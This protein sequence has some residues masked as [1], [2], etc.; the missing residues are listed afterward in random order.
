VRIIKEKISLKTRIKML[1]SALDWLT[2][3]WIP[4][5][6]PETKKWTIVRFSFRERLSC[7]WAGVETAILGYWYKGVNENG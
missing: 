4:E 7:F 5:Y 6:D 3:T 2:T 1:I